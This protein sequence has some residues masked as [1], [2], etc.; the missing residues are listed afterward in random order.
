[1]AAD[2]TQTE[3]SW[4][5][6]IYLPREPG[7]G[8]G[9]YQ[10]L[11]DKGSTEQ[12]QIGSAVA[13]ETAEGVFI[14]SVTDMRTVGSDADPVMA[15]SGVGG[16]LGDRNHHDLTVMVATVTVFRSPALRPI[17]SGRV[18][19]AT[20][21][22]VLLATGADKMEQPLPVGLIELAHGE[23]APA[24]VDGHYLNG[25]QAGHLIVNGL[26]G[27]AAKTSFTTFLLSSAIAHGDPEA[28]STAAILFSPKGQ[29]L[30]YLDQPPSAGYELT[31]T[32]LAMYEAAGIP[33]EPFTDFEVWA[34][35]LPGGTQINCPRQDA[36]VQALRWDLKQVWPF[37]RYLFPWMHEDEKL[38]SFMR[39]FEGQKL[40]TDNRAE[41]ISTFA[42]LDRFFEQQI[43][44]GNANE[45]SICPFA[46]THVATMWRIR[47]MIMSLPERCRGLLTDGASRSHEDIPD[48]GWRHGQVATVDIAGLP[49][50]VQAIVIARTLER[51]LKAA[52]DGRLGVDHLVVF[53]DEL[54]QMAPKSGSEMAAVRKILERASTQGRYAGISLWGATQK[55]S[56]IHEILVDNAATKA[57]GMT[58]DGELADAAYG[59]MSAGLTEMIAT[60]PKGQM[61]ITHH[62][63]RGPLVVRF[64][65]PAWRTGKPTTTGGGTGRP[66][67]TDVLTNGG[68]K[69]R[70]TTLER[71][72]EGVD[73]ET[74]A[75]II[76]RADD[77][78]AA[79]E[80]LK[81]ARV[82]DMARVEL[83][84]TDTAPVDPSDPFGLD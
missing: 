37:L 32:D 66:K 69:L 57:I 6:D 50:D 47:R 17:R 7:T 48:Q 80:A 33:A 15:D 38:Q 84:R 14:G 39:S 27:L 54:N 23:V 68:R 34:P 81:K 45:R 75:R 9:T 11:V 52:E 19:A 55:M 4:F 40:Y 61:A 53:V 43:E 28:D 73:E 42:D 63:Y 30:L 41:R 74:A 76:S 82:P 65:R 51:L 58:S 22:E 24:Y 29:D 31:E 5:G 67:I 71:L 78:E 59:R 62:S 49:Q 70:E 77:G 18:R 1:M 21:E 10:F 3:T 83:P 44:D 2:E 60:L 36:A 26:S 56:K 35:G 46:N 20:R 13:A 79:V 25:P 72:T 8:V 64:P 16:V 12:V